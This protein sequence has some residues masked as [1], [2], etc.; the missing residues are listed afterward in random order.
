M[1]IKTAAELNDWCRCQAAAQIRELDAVAADHA[2]QCVASVVWRNAIG[3]G[4]RL[5]DDWSWVL[6]LYD[7]PAIDEIVQAAAGSAAADRRRR[8][9]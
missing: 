6:E 9:R 4:L 1:I 5:G 8:G 2:V 3:Q 7:A